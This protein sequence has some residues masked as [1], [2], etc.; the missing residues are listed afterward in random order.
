MRERVSLLPNLGKTMVK[1]AHFWQY[2]VKLRTLA[3]LGET[4]QS[5]IKHHPAGLSLIILKCTQSECC[6][7]VVL[8]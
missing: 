3:T 1:L 5:V 7:I 6:N 2:L 4:W 8:I